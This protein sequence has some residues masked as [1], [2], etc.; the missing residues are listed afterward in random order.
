MTGGRIDLSLS[1]PGRFHNAILLR[2]NLADHAILSADEMVK[3]SVWEFCDERRAALLVSGLFQNLKVAHI[4][5]WQNDILGAAWRGAQA[6][7]KDVIARREHWE[8]VRDKPQIW[9]SVETFGGPELCRSHDLPEDSWMTAIVLME[10]QGADLDKKELTGVRGLTIGTVWQVPKGRH[11]VLRIYPR[12][13]ENEPWLPSLPSDVAAAMAFLKTRLVSVE[14]ERGSRQVRR[15][16]ERRG[17]Q[18]P[19]I[20]VVSLRRRER[21]QNDG[22]HIHVDWSCRW[23]VQG[24]WR[25]LHAPRKLDGMPTTYVLP[26]LKGPEDKPLRVPVERIA[27]VDR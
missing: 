18:L 13:R 27:T 25:K 22:D 9:F 2:D 17:V 3:S 26:Y 15:A 23:I 1:G 16:A 12:Q 14:T 6:A 24:H 5:L 8:Q 11:P 20:Q 19:E 10:S 7:W 21:R 4:Y